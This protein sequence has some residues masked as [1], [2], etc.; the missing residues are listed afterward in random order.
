METFVCSEYLIPVPLWIS[1]S[2]IEPSEYVIWFSPM[3]VIYDSY[4]PREIS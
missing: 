1:G 3:I 4:I 2:L